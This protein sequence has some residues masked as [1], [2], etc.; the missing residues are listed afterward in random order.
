M[1]E[2]RIKIALVAISV[3]AAVILALTQF[4]YNF[5]EAAADRAPAS[6]ANAPEL[7]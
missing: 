5:G 7:E 3:F 6:A 1:E 4:H 2:R